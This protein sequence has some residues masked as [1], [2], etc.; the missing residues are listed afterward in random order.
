MRYLDGFEDASHGYDPVWSR[1]KEDSGNE[2][3]SCSDRN[4]RGE[5]KHVHFVLKFWGRRGAAHFGRI[6]VIFFFRRRTCL[7]RISHFG[8]KS[9]PQLSREEEA[10]AIVMDFIPRRGYGPE[11]LGWEP[12]IT[13]QGAEWVLMSNICCRLASMTAFGI[14]KQSFSL[15]PT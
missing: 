1:Y 7:R 11:T 6:Y 14:P 15:I 4:K 2:K 8:E 5:T 3:K 13:L 9:D 10:N 12:F